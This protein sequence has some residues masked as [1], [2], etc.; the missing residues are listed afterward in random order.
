[1]KRAVERTSPERAKV[2]L[3]KKIYRAWKYVRRMRHLLR[4]VRRLA[5]PRRRVPVSVEVVE[6]QRLR[7][8]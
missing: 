6:E 2:S 4:P 3:A 5:S 7:R 1:V 8:S